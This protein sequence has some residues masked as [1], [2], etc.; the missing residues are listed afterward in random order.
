MRIRWRE[1]R[2][3]RDGGKMSAPTLTAYASDSD[4]PA[5]LT[6]DLVNSNVIAAKT[7]AA[8]TIDPDTSILGGPSAAN[9]IAILDSIGG[10]ATLHVLPTTVGKYYGTTAREYAVA[11]TDHIRLLV[12]E[13]Q[14]VHVHNRHQSAELVVSHFRRNDTTGRIHNIGYERVKSLGSTIVGAKQA[15]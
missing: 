15:L 12:I 8:L 5:G 3:R 14:V 13:G 6:I 7:N 4:V 9:N 11:I 1:K 10:S 2:S